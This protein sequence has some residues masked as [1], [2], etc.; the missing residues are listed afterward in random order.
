MPRPFG[1]GW[2]QVTDYMPMTNLP[3]IGDAEPLWMGKTFVNYAA[4]MS[5]R[6]SK[7]ELVARLAARLE[8]DEKTA[9]VWL[10][11]L[12]DEIAAAVRAGES[13]TLPNLGGF[14]VKQKRDG[15]VFKFNPSQKLRAIL[16]WSSTY[17]GDL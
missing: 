14:Y 10:D 16:G 15:T 17:K 1:R 8:T 6:V 11:A 3:A 4:I 9:A 5:D 12:T 2:C 13:V 7:K